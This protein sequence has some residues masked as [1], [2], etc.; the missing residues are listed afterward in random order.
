MLPTESH[1]A[2]IKAAIQAREHAY[3]PYSNFRV[4]AGLICTDG[5]IS[6]GASI[7]NASYGASIC[8][9]QTAI[10]NAIS[11]GK[12]EFSALA[13]VS[14]VITPIS[15]CGTCRQVIREFCHIDMPVLLVPGDYPRRED[16]SENVDGNGVIEVTVG[17]LLPQSLGPEFSV[18]T[19]GFAWGRQ[20]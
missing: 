17:E 14:D 10:V 13:I 8:A 1:E 20:D 3:S 2:L 4:G 12:K 15:P 7:D 19:T 16:N 18:R 9:E 5:T 6:K 11:E